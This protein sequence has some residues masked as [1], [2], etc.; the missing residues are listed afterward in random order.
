MLRKFQ[1]ITLVPPFPT[2]VKSLNR[3]GVIR[4]IDLRHNHAHYEMADMQKHHHLVCVYC[5]R[6]EDVRECGVEEMQETIARRSKH[7]AA[8]KTHS[9]EFYGICKSCVKK[10]NASNDAQ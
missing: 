2:S 7:F 6:I 1:G 5:G 10:E 3:K 8:V 9:L 4:Q